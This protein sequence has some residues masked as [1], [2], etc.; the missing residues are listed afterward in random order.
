MTG[1]EGNE[2]FK[3][4]MGVSKQK[5]LMLC[6]PRRQALTELSS[7]KLINPNNPPAMFETAE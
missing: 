3:K 5:N 7:L 4:R 6:A 2:F 1:C